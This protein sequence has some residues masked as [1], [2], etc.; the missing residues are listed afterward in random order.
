MG[1]NLTFLALNA[2][3]QGYLAALML[4]SFILLLIALIAEL[5]GKKD[6]IRGSALFALIITSLICFS[7]FME[8]IYFQNYQTKFELL[9]ITRI[10]DVIP[11]YSYIIVG[12]ASIIFAIYVIYDMFQYNK[13]SIN[14]FS[15]KE[16]IENLPTGIAFM[17]KDIDL[18]L[19]NHI[20]NG[21][22]KE[23]TG[24]ALHS[25]EELW[26]DILE[27]QSQDACVLD[28]KEPAFVLSTGEIWQF[29][30]TTC[31]WNGANYEQIKATDITQLYKLSVHAKRVNEK[32]LKQQQRLKELTDRIEQN[33]EQQ[34]TVN[35]KVNFHDNF[36]NLLTLTKKMLREKPDIDES[37]ALIQYWED[38]TDMIHELSS[39]DKH[40]LTLEQIKLFAAKLGFRLLIDG[41][42]PTE[43]HHRMTILLCINE[44]LKNSHRHANTD[45]L[46]VHISQTE[47]MI[48][49]HIHNDDKN[50][51][52]KIKEGG[53]LLGLRQRIEQSGG[54]MEL[55]CKRGVTM[56]VKLYK[57]KDG[58]TDV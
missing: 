54:E 55:S 57:E 1:R 37:R 26:A 15:V 27:L 13:S 56:M 9:E 4:L 20:M 18:C 12:V 58:D 5:M 34:V 50:P 35:M 10:I 14:R 36:G 30:K 24:K 39:E 11:L 6:I 25:G 28:S 42:L 3:A 29:S 48:L 40:K 21:L 8:R 19:S 49:M 53:G 51:P 38:L 32:L 2:T 16:A 47:E 52:F 44:M 23:L 43:K 45:R 22:S 41:E 17:T 33:V 7:A 31:V 46:E